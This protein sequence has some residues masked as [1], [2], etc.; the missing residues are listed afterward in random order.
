MTATVTSWLILTGILGLSASLAIWA[1]GASRA[2]GLAVLAFVLATP[3]SGAALA[4]AL[5]WAIPYWPGITVPEGEHPLLGV[6][7]VEGEAIYI[8]LDI[9]DGEP[10]YYR[11][12][13]S[14]ETAQ[15]LQSAQE[16]AGED[17]EV[18]LKVPPFDPSL[19]E[20]GPMFYADPQE[21]MPPKPVQPEA[22]HFEG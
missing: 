9:G 2:R 22:P 16:G 20:L 17:G 3:I 13:W 14:I 5:G 12:P 15:K 7:M 6:K 1:R 4:T 11:L 8:L 18:G 19:D 10:R 21:A